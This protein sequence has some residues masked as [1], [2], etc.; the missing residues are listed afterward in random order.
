MNNEFRFFPEQASTLAPEVDALTLFVVATTV[1]VTLL[2]F[3]LLL[4]FAV[5]FRRRSDDHY[6][7]PIHGNVP[8]E[9]IWCVIPTVI[10]VVMFVWGVKVYSNIVVA[11]VDSMDIYVVGRQWMWKI[12][13][14]SGQ[15]EI[16]ALHVP[17][18]RPVKLTITSEDVIHSFFVPAFRVKQDAVPGRYTSMWFQ[19]TKPGVYQIYCAEYCGTEHSRM[20][21]K[22][23]VMEEGD[24]QKWL[25]EGAENGQA[26]QGRKL[27]T[28]LQCITCHSGNAQAKAPNL[29]GI[30]RK[31]IPISHQSGVKTPE[32]TKIFADDSYLR[33]SILYPNAK[34]AAGWES[35]M[36][37]YQGLAT[38]EEL[39]QVIAYIRSLQQGQTPPRL[40][41]TPTPASIQEKSSQKGEK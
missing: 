12:Q 9:I 36:P 7:K 8:L 21:G 4:L 5:L 11:P 26:L 34:V 1:G 40:E 38:E 22:V 23:T 15:R 18:G 39:L 14:P 13:H 32:G 41:T 30:Y 20:I 16:N 10:C 2:V 37:T 27:F 17:V 25:S 28:K 19:A 31:H 3:F 6:P 33:E 24:F 29:E 35:I